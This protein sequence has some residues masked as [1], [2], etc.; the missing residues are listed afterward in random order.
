MCVLAFALVLLTACDEPELHASDESIERMFRHNQS[1][2]TKLISMSSQDG[3]DV[4]WLMTHENEPSDTLLPPERWHAYDDVI[5][6]TGVRSLHSTGKGIEMTLGFASDDF[7]KEGLVKGL[8]YSHK[9]LSP[10]IASLD[11]GL[12][13]DLAESGTH[14]AYKQLAPGWYLFIRQE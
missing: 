3:V 8:V 11:G 9:S 13:A 12:P 6:G 5:R 4:L 1:R 2:L 10:Q 14:E 7:M